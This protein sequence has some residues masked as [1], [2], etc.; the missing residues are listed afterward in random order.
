MFIVTIDCGTTNSRLYIVD[1]N[2]KI[3]IK[4]SKKIGIRNVAINGDNKILKHGLWTM[5]DQALKETG[6][7]TSEI[8]C[9]L[10]SGVITSELGLKELPHLWAPCSLDTLA[11]SIVYFK[12][13]DVFPS[14]I[15][16]YF[17]R[18]IKNYYDQ[19]KF[20]LRNIYILDVMRG[21]ETQIAGLL[22]DK[23][24]KLPVIVLMLSSHTKLIPIDNEE[25]ILGSITTLSG[26]IYEAIIKETLIGKS[27]RD[28]DGFDYTGYFN[29][30]IFDVAYKQVT[31]SGFLRGLMCIRLMDIL[32]H[33][34]WYE[35]KFFLESLL[36]VEDM[37]IF[38]QVKD[39]TNLSITNYILIGPKFRC[40]LYKYILETKISPGCDVNIIAEETQIDQLSIKGILSLAKKAKIF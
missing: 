39:F 17:V 36:A 37:S 25:R 29:T 21:E 33:I 30:D 16:V 10:S 1:I 4:V 6:I 31:N 19:D 24:I 7:S 11:A 26:Q 5:F 27:I 18:G 20:S 23:K 13:L 38:S 3:I 15:P 8:H 9:I 12:S 40:L 22:D 34:P 2:G 14:S 35:R 28:E 32:V